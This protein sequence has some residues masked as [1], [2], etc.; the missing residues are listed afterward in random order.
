MLVVAKCRATCQRVPRYLYLVAR[1]RRVLRL[2]RP[3][4]ERVFRR[5][6]SR[7]AR[8][9]QRYQTDRSHSGLRG[10]RGLGRRRRFRDAATG[11]ITD[12]S[13]PARDYR[14]RVRGVFVTTESWLTAKAVPSQHGRM[15]SIYMV[16]TFLALA[17][18]QLLIARADIR[19]SAPFN[20]IVTLFAV[21]LVMVTTTR[22]EAPQVANV[23][24]L[25]CAVFTRTAPIA[26]AGCALSGLIGGTF[27]SLVPAWMQQQGTPRETIALFMLVSVLGGLAFQIP[28]GRVSD[29]FDRRIVLASLSIGFAA[30]AFVMVVLPRSLSTVLPAAALLGG[31]MSTLYPVCVAY[32]HDRMPADRVLAVSG[33]LILVNGIGS[34]AG[35]LMGASVMERFAID[36]VF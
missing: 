7:R 35:P 9:Q 36:G 23:A 2:P 15:F 28:V 24:A 33:R 12:L 22:A 18:G 13:V 20:T 29:R 30:T 19:V 11:P 10:I 16:G 34:F 14:F 26:V 31:F 6:H 4:V 8:L 21:A 27:Y 1:G 17:L 5:L 3:G 25:P 32:A